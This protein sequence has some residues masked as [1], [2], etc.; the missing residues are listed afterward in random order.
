MDQWYEPPKSNW[1][2][3]IVVLKLTAFEAGA[4][5]AILHAE[6]RRGESTFPVNK[7]GPN[8]EPIEIPMIDRLIE[9][10][11]EQVKEVF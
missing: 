5:A 10:L 9:K 7:P 11:N 8:G 2:P 6:K 1:L 3:E 4:L